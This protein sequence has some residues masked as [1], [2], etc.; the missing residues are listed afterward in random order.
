MNNKNIGVVYILVNEA[1]PNIIKIGKTEKT[2]E[3]RLK[4]LDNT[5]IPLPF[6][7]YFAAKVNNYHEVEKKLHYAFG[8]YR[9][10]NNREFFNI[11]ADRVKSILDLLILNDVTP[12]D[13][14]V[15]DISDI[16]AIKNFEKRKRLKFSM[17]KIPIGATLYFTKDESIIVTVKSDNTVLLN[18]KEMLLSPAAAS[19]LI[20]NFNY[21]KNISVQ[22][23]AY[24]K[25]KENSDDDFE[26]LSD[27][28][29]RLEKEN[30][31]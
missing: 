2:I 31:E 9:I 29:L 24:W 17:I 25:Y 7:C 21:N 15:N 26:V 5:S 11:S 22:G 12:K 20:N 18:D 13:N 1:M 8:D 4:S 6:Q 10:R 3:E 27:R 23:A 16:E 14:I 30:N 28:R 19:V